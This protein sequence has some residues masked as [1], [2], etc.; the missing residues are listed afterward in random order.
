M[1]YTLDFQWASGDNVESYKEKVSSDQAIQLHF[2][3]GNL[4]AQRGLVLFWD[5]TVRECQG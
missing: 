5:H 2:T 4:E 3:E 1:L